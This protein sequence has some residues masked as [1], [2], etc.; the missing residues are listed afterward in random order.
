MFTLKE[1][2]SK[3]IVNS[4]NDECLNSLLETYRQKY[5]VYSAYSHHKKVGN[6]FAFY[7]FVG[8]LSSENYEKCEELINKNNTQEAL[9]LYLMYYL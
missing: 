3:N 1:L 4:L 9:L 2:T 6:G 7:S 8:L 5:T